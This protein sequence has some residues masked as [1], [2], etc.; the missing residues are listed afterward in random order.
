MFHFCSTQI[1]M[2]ASSIASNIAIVFTFLVGFLLYLGK[3]QFVMKMLAARTHV[4]VF[5]HSLALCL[6]VSGDEKNM[7]LHA[8]YD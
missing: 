4:N 3:L 1:T 6:S 2:V 8:I 5:N 7:T